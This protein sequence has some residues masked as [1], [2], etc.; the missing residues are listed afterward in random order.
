MNYNNIQSILTSSSPA[1]T[2]TNYSSPILTPHTPVCLMSDNTSIQSSVFR[3]TDGDFHDSPMY[4]AVVESH[5][6]TSK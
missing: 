5:L 4:Y 6:L 2:P 1:P 3:D